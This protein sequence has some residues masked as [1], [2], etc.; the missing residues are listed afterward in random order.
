[1]DTDSHARK[2]QKDLSSGTVSLAM[3]A[4]LNAAREPLYGY[5]IAKLLEERAG[6]T[7]TGKQSALYPVLRNQEAAGLLESTVE[8]SL[9]GPPRRYYTITALGR[10]TLKAWTAIWNDTRNS[11]DAVLKEGLS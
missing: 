8:P 10:E 4:V 11:I 9:A 7:L 6:G 3:L 2:F 1:M 5:Q